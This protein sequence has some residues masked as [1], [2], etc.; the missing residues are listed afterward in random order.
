KA[1]DVLGHISYS[2]S[3]QPVS[4]EN[5]P[6]LAYQDLVG[7]TSPDQAEADRLSKRRQS[8]LDLVSVEYK[9]LL[10]RTD[11]SKDDRTKLDAHFTSV[12]NLEMGMQNGLTCNLPP[13]SVS[14]M[15]GL[16]PNTITY[17]SEYKTIGEMQMDIIAMT[18][19]CGANSVATLQWGNGA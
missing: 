13:N 14:A 11:L 4:G 2:G 16:D 1:D 9:A 18:I 15:Q 10:A 6:W 12:R 19:A 8:V 3:E 17:D 7:V 5:N